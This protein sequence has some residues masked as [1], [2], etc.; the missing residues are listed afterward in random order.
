MKSHAGPTTI[1]VVD[2]E[3]FVIR[4]LERVF[5]VKR[6]HVLTAESGSDA[7]RILKTTDKPVRLIIADQRMPG[8]TGDVFLE[9]SMAYF[10]FAVRF[11]LTGHA[12]MAVLTKAV[13]SG[14]IHRYVSKPWNSDD[15]LRAVEKSLARQ[16]ALLKGEAALYSRGED[17]RKFKEFNQGTEAYVFR[18][19]DP[20]RLNLDD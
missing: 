13:N 18:G 6:Y 5:G 12:D 9:R 17:M 8:M 1:M 14:G 2:D 7:L 3:P 15:L 19:E 10:P 4:S 11:L 16:D 20:F